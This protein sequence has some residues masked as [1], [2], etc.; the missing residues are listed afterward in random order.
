MTP[1]QQS[2]LEGLAGRALTPDE[3]VAIASHLA[4]RNDV[5]IAA[6]LSA[7]RVQLESHPIGHGTILEMMPAHGGEFIDTLE[8]IGTQ[9]RNVYWGIQPL[10]RGAFDLGLQASQDK[11]NWLKTSIVPQFADE[12]TALQALGYAPAP[13]SIDFVSR[14]LN[15]AEGRV[16]L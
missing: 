10:N 8:S 5:A 16:S 3:S 9:N 13:L 1:A 4:I 15:A 7:G 14:A 2:A 11:L 12:I 6:L